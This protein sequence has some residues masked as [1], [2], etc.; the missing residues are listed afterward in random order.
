M[1]KG[2]R[3]LALAMLGLAGLLLAA[4]TALA[5][6]VERVGDYRI[7]YSAVSTLFLTPEIVAAYDIER[8]KH[9]GLLNVSVLQAEPD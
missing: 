6:Q 1:R 7:H 4:G 5:Q 2:T 9:T 3:T 8:S